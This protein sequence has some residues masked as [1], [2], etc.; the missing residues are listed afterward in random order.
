[1][2]AFIKKYGIF[3]L[4]LIL[5]WNAFSHYK[6]IGPG[7]QVLRADGKAYY[8]Y[9]PAVFIY[10]DSQFQFIDYYEHKYNLPQ[11]Y[12]DFRNRV[13]GLYVNK[14][15]AGVAILQF[16]FFLIAHCASLVLH[17]EADGYAPLY[18]QFFVLGSLVY[19]FLGMQYFFLY[20]LTLK[21]KPVIALFVILLM[22]FGA[23]AYHYAVYEQCMSHIFSLSMFGV[24]IYGMSRVVSGSKRWLVISCFI[25]GMIAILRPVNFMIVAF[26]PFIAGSVQNLKSLFLFII[27]EYKFFLV[28]I[29]AALIPFIIQMLLWRW[30]TG[31]FFVYSYGNEGI[32]WINPKIGHILFG[33]RK[34]WFVWTPI[35]FAG[36]CGLLFLWKDK[37]RFFS[38]VLFGLIIIYIC[39]CWWTADY[40]SGFG[41]R[42]LVEFLFIPAVGIALILNSLKKLA[43][44]VS[45]FVMCM[46]L[47]FVN[48][49]Q[50]Y[51]YR[52]HII[53]WDSMNK[54]YY[55]QVFMKTGKPYEH[56]L[57]EKFNFKPAMLIAS[58]IDKSFD[59][60]FETKG[61]WIN[62]SNRRN[63]FVKD[64]KWA[65]IIDS[66]LNFSSTFQHV[67]SAEEIEH[68]SLIQASVWFCGPFPGE[69]SLV[70]SFN[71]PDHTFIWN[72]LK[73]RKFM[74]YPY[75]WTQAVYQVSIPHNLPFGSD[76]TCFVYSGDLKKPIYLDDFKIDFI[77][78]K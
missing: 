64:G 53:M 59:N 73:L 67:F 35:A 56:W 39:S 21:I 6:H 72:D 8:A 68:D 16:P 2:E 29:L 38:I 19:L 69:T 24:F 11:D 74:T 76:I 22:L 32:E 45:A 57:E 10:H 30:Q 42:V 5:S 33:F 3:L 48:Q 15:F 13:D 65:T 18:L 60:N 40:G 17:L 41:S 49:V 62:D 50:A 70:I 31:K 28:G 27:R 51:Q 25:L 12:A 37:F 7:N 47:I 58:N 55:F 52:H 23:N 43:I 61:L 14:Y 66:K 78:K 77:K 44:K 36:I 63:T 46:M 71:K 4:I 54:D 26:I 20:L 75:T 9:L 34:G 1:M